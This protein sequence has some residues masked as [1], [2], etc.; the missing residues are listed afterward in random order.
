MDILTDKTVNTRKPHLCHGCAKSYGSGTKM[1]YTTSVD[2]GEITSA[3]WCKTC[4]VLIDKTYD[5]FDLQD[6]IEFGS[7]RDG[8]VQAWESIN[9][10]NT[11]VDL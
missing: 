5:Y 10:W 3:Y 7:V 4:E 8:D 11:N 2:E 6:G 9:K 1:R